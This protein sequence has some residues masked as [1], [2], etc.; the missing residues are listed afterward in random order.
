MRQEHA[1]HLAA[2]IVEFCRLLRTHGF[3]GDLRQALT[4]L[5]AATHID[6]AGKQSFACALQAALCC[7]KEEWEKFPQLFWQFWGESASAASFCCRRVPRTLRQRR[8]HS[9]APTA[10][11]SSSSNPE[12]PR[13]RR[14]EREE[15]FMAQAPSID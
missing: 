8:V 5:E 7:N 11:P 14:R 13:R 1:E 15:P 3:S 4:A 6:I 2:S 10:L 9:N 12:A